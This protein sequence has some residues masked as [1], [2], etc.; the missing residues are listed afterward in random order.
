MHEVLIDGE[1]L[2]IENIV[3]VA[4]ENAEVAIP[5]KVKKRIRK[6]REV[7]ENLIKK[8][9]VI[10]GVNTGFGALSNVTIPSQFLQ[11]ATS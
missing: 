5:E 9:Q 2:T 7:L 1:T 6:S 3:K 4:R 10:Y 11:A 8:G